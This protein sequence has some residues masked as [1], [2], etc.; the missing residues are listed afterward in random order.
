MKKGVNVLGLIAILMIIGSAFVCVV[1][2]ESSKEVGVAG[3]TDIGDSTKT[4]GVSASSTLISTLSQS[5]HNLNTSESFSTIQA[6]IDDSDTLNG[7]TITVDAGTYTENVDVTKSLTIRSTSGNP[8]D[9]IVQAADPNDHIFEVTADYVN[10]RGFTVKEGYRGITLYSYSENNI[11]L[12]NIC[13]N[14]YRGIYIASASGNNTITN[15][16]CKNNGVGIFICSDRGNN[17]VTSNTCENNTDGIS[18]WFSDGDNTLTNNIMSGNKHNF[19]VRGDDLCQYIHNIDT[20]NKVDGKPIYYLINKENQQVPSDAGYVAIVNSINMIVKNLTLTNNG[21]GVLL[22]YST[23]S[24]VQNVNATDNY[25][26]IRLHRS[27]NNTIIDNKVSNN[28]YGI[29]LYYAPHGLA[30]CTNNVVTDNSISNNE[31][32]IEIGRVMN[33]TIIRNNISNNCFGVS[34]AQFVGVNH[35]C[36][37]NFIST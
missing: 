14:N 8:E 12:D 32:G 11:I 9:T 36:L 1:T 13:E 17:V 24:K 30:S 22:A 25:F 3:E 5:V 10:I 4:I 31:F 19:E 35:V 37:N 21:D 7:H 18:L 27:S 16:I 34:V 6:A 23:D 15:N 29:Y 28:P 2:A 33:D 26:G 20:S